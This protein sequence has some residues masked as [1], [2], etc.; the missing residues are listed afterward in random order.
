M[1]CTHINA[2]KTLINIKLNKHGMVAYACAQ[3]SKVQTVGS[4]GFWPSILHQLVS[5]RPMRN[6]VSKEMDSIPEDDLEVIL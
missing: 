5:S 3:S 2:D 1:W 4:P 6:P